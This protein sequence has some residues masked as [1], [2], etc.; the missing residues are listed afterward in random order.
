MKESEPGCVNGILYDAGAWPGLV[1]GGAGVVY[2]EWLR[3]DHAALAV[4]DELE[5]YYG[6]DDERN[7][8]ERLPIADCRSGRMGIAYVWRD[9]RGY[10]PLASGRWTEGDRNLG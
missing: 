8:Y 3:L 6:P 4:L 9:G 2:G 10:P 5:D 7:D 1:P